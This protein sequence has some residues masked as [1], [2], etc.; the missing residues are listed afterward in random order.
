M[1]L[2]KHTLSLIIY[3]SRFFSGSFHRLLDFINF[4]LTSLSFPISKWFVSFDNVEIINL[5]FVYFC[6]HN[7]TNLTI[8]FSL[9]FYLFLKSLF[10]F[11]STIFSSLHHHLSFQT[12]MFHLTLLKLLFVG[13]TFSFIIVFLILLL[14]F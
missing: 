3:I 10:Q 5:L 6:F 11:I 4:L 14:F 13:C 1:S 12:G 9:L 2:Y 7:F 8:F